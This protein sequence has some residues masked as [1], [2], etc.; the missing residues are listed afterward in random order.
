MNSIFADSIATALATLIT[1]QQS[2]RKIVDLAAES[3]VADETAV[4]MTET[5]P[6]CWRVT[7]YLR[8]EPD[9]EALRELVAAAAGSEA[10]R[11]LSFGQLAAKDW[12]GESLAGLKPVAAGRFMVH[13]AHDRTTVPINRISIEIEAALAFGTGHH[14]TTRGCLL[15]LDRLSRS[16][17]TAKPKRI[18]DLGTGTGV[19][20][21]AAARA[22]HRRVLATDLDRDAVRVAR[23]NARLNGIGP[24]VEIVHANGLTNPSIRSRAPFD[25]VFANI[26]L[27]PLQKLAVPLCKS[28][29]PGGHLV[30]SGLLSSQATA[31][32]SFYRALTLQRRINIDGW[33]TLIL[34]RPRRFD[35]RIAHGGKR[36]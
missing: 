5:A 15:A 25:L 2:A 4:S 1:D 8:E 11:A 28:I 34:K 23:E 16:F 26:L 12:V 6:G 13:G 14:G 21:F 35:S 24:L 29:A 10:G 9:E 3:L 27:G 18:L 36:P 30:L 31:A 32:L 22:M 19:L 20:A 17:G 7:I 33:T